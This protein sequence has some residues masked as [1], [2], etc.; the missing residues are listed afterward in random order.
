MRTKNMREHPGERRELAPRRYFMGEE[1]EAITDKVYD[2]F[3]I[4]GTM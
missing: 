4:L 2:Q 3:C 1:E